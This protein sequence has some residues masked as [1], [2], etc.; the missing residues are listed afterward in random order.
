MGER[1][2]LVP[3]EIKKISYTFRG[4]YLLTTLNNEGAEV[5][6]YPG[7]GAIRRRLRSH[8]NDV[9]KFEAW[10]FYFKIIDDEDQFFLEECRLFHLYGEQLALLNKQHPPKLYGYCPYCDKKKEALIMP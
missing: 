7:R 9:S 6:I 8:L 5:V 10:F 2:P 4:V 1:H 3:D